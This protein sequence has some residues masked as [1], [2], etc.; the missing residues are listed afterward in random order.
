MIDNAVEMKGLSLFD[1]SAKQG[2]QTKT[3]IFEISVTRQLEAR[4]I[5]IPMLN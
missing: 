3:I 1:W 5:R 4:F 2:Y